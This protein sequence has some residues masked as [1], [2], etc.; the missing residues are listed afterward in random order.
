MPPGVRRVHLRPRGAPVEQRYHST[1]PAHAFARAERT[2]G[3]TLAERTAFERDGF[4]ILRGVIPP[5]EYPVDAS[6]AQY[7][8][9]AAT[10]LS[11]APTPLHALIVPCN[12]LSVPSNAL[13]QRADSM[14][15]GM[16]QCGERAV[17]RV[18]RTVQR[19]ER[20]AYSIGSTR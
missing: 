5:A 9:S 20:R 16:T 1:C 19:D 2:T 4:V 17:Q 18:E 10:K 15:G 14:D 13:A 12:A 3:R 8:A 6:P 11:I 7:S